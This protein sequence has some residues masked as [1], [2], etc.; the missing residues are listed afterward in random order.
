MSDTGSKCPEMIGYVGDVRSLEKSNGSGVA[1][2]DKKIYN[3]VKQSNSTPY[4]TLFYSQDDIWNIGKIRTKLLEINPDLKI[5]QI[6]DIQAFINHIYSG[7]DRGKHPVKSIQMINVQSVWGTDNI[8]EYVEDKHQQQE[9]RKQQ[10]KE[11]KKLVHNILLNNQTVEAYQ[12]KYHWDESKTFADN[13]LDAAGKGKESMDNLKDMRQG[14]FKTF[15]PIKVTIKTGDRI[16]D[17]VM[18]KG[19]IGDT[20]K[21]SVSSKNVLK[22]MK[23]GGGI[24]DVYGAYKSIDTL[25]KSAKT[26]NKSKKQI[27]EEFNSCMEDSKDFKSPSFGKQDRCMQIKA[28]ESMKSIVKFISEGSGHPEFKDELMKSG[29]L[30]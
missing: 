25:G 24:A 3:W 1:I 18:I 17:G 12:E 15:D 10:I 7:M 16:K 5:K 22:G 2:D 13:I 28:E 8:E 9:E 26:L 6:S 27:E 4:A 21:N 30:K 29:G 23:V 11:T 14:K 19:T 20:V